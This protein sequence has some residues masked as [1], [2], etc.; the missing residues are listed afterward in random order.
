MPPK[1][2]ADFGRACLIFFIFLSAGLPTGLF[3]EILRGLQ[4]IDLVNWLLIGGLTLNRSVLA[5]AL[6]S[7][8]SFPL[9]MLGSIATAVLPCSP[10]PRSRP[11]PA[12]S[13]SLGVKPWWVSPPSPVDGNTSAHC[14]TADSALP[15]SP[16]LT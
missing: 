9:F 14:A 4:R 12:S 5:I 6:L 7:D 11:A 16:D 13:I 3:S 15:Q 2:R 10:S 8:W 1:H